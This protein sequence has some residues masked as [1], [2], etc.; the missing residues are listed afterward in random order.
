MQLL[1]NFINKIY[2]HRSM[3][4]K[5]VTLKVNSRLY[6]AYRL[7]CKQNGLLVSQQFEIMMEEKI[8]T[9][10]KKNNLSISQLDNNIKKYM[11]SLTG[12][13]FMIHENKIIANLLLD[14]RSISFIKKIVLKENLFG[15]KT[16][17]SVSKRVNSILK[18]ISNLDP[19]LL[20]KITS[21][22]SGDGKIV[23]LYSI[24]LRDRLFNELLTELISYK[25][26]IRDFEFEKRLIL[27]F[28]NDKAESEQK[29]QDFTKL[30]KYRLS[31]VMFNMCKESGLIEPSSESFKLNSLS[32]SS[33]LKK[34]FEINK[35][36]KFL[37][38]IGVLL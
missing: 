15:Y 7:Y 37:K 25:F 27:D 24:Y 10:Y 28:I 21:D 38:C 23:I 20:N 13:P 16:I 34:Y 1:N 2:I 32:I 6:H 30:T 12:E 14:N 29:I 35:N 3:E 19:F 36:K 11:G 4:T 31:N 22:L 8:G 17:K 5:N 26:S 9:E 18:R 33:D